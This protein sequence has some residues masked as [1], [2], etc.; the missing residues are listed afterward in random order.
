MHDEDW[1]GSKKKKPKN[2]ISKK[3]GGLFGV[4]SVFFSNTVVTCYIILIFIALL[5]HSIR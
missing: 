1:G 5:S 4:Y 3:S 2:F